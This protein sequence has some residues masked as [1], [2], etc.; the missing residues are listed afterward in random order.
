MMA[1]DLRRPVLATLT[2]GA[3]CVLSGA[4]G[5]Q[6]LSQ[7]VRFVR[8][9][10]PKPLGRVDSR[11]RSGANVELIAMTPRDDGPMTSTLQPALYWFLSGQSERS[12]TF[13]L[14]LHRSRDP[15]P[16]F[17][18]EIRGPVPAGVHAIKLGDHKVSLKGNLDYS[19]YVTLGES[20]GNQPPPTI[21]SFIVVPDQSAMKGLR[22]ELAAASLEG[23]YKVYARRSFWYDALATIVML[24]ESVPLSTDYRN[25][26]VELLKDGGLDD[27]AARV[28]PPARAPT[29]C[30]PKS[31]P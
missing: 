20:S 18:C 21:T 8:P 27:V 5:A 17:Q 6:E 26:Y 15:L 2:I 13:S 29:T 23:R 31:L 7:P 9:A 25:R 22:E 4:V 12:A 16:I 11:V 30:S 14:R 24:M 3:A 28:A 10:N 1:I 19:W